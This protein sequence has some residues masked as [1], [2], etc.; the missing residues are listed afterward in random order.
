[1]FLDQEFLNIGLGREIECNTSKNYSLCFK[2]VMVDLSWKR[3]HSLHLCLG[4]LIERLDLMMSDRAWHKFLAPPGEA[5]SSRVGLHLR[6][7]VIFEHH[8]VELCRS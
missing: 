5:L 1:M 7:A 2:V 4:F 8:H 6:L 3:S